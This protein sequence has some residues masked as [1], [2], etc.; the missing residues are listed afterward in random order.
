[1]KEHDV[2]KLFMVR[3]GKDSFQALSKSD[4]R[5][6]TVVVSGHIG[7]AVCSP[8]DKFDLRVGVPLA[9]KRVLHYIQGV[10]RPRFTREFFRLWPEAHPHF[11]WCPE[12]PF[13]GYKWCGRCA[14]THRIPG[15]YPVVIPPICEFCGDEH[16]TGS[17]P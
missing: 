7:T 14:G 15:I 2:L 9:L 6:V 12:H 5:V 16:M 8:D 4:G 1:M 10:N 3:V 17:C 13:P 11:K